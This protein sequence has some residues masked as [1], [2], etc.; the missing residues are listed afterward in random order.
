MFEDA[1]LTQHPEWKLLFDAFKGSEYGTFI[2][3]GDIQHILGCNRSERKYYALVK[4]WKR[5]MLKEACRQIEC[6]NN[7]GY[8]VVR[9]EAFRLSARRQLK[10]AHR[11]MRTAGEI[12]VKAPVELLSDE[13]KAKLGVVGTLVSQLL[14]FSKATLKKVKEVEKPTDKLVLEVGKALDVAD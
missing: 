6:L 7:K 5:E 3:H 13:E 11:R 2:P 14:H 4:R 9:P 1:A 12:V 10:F 8:E